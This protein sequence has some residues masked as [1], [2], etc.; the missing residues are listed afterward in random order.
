MHC[1]IWTLGCHH[2]AQSALQALARAERDL[3]LARQDVQMLRQERREAQQAQERV[4][5][6][7]KELAGLSG[8]QEELVRAEKVQAYFHTILTM[9][10]IER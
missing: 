6:L 8:S 9:P 4:R 7:E 3:Q 10:I 1:C 5:A 2:K